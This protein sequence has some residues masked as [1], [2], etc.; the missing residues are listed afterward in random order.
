MRMPAS[1]P[2][3]PLVALS[4]GTV[5]GLAWL[6]REDFESAT[7]VA[8]FATISLACLPIIGRW[9]T[10]RH[11][12]CIGGPICGLVSGMCAIDLC[13]D[14]CVVSNWQVSDGVAALDARRLAW[15]YYRT[16]LKSSHVNG[17]LL[18]IMLVS[19]LG[20]AVGATRSPW[21]VLK[22]WTTIGAV[23]SLGCGGYVT[24]CLPRYLTIRDAVAYDAAFFDG[25][26]SVVA[27]RMGLFASTAIVTVLLFSL[28]LGS[29][30]ASGG[31]ELHTA[32]DSKQRSE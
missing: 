16:V 11:L 2:E 7:D 8:V 1:L 12:A 19:I 18:A 22:Q 14:L 21:C 17:L 24:C 30:Q 20:A 26:E 10:H 28:Q 23:M 3:L 15:L 27:A 32:A 9:T 25:W 13:F 5:A 6:V 4:A 29:A 31:T